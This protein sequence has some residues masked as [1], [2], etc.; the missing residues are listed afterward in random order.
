MNSI[1]QDDTAGKKK[2]AEEGNQS[3]QEIINQLREHQK[4]IQVNPVET[5]RKVS[6]CSKI[7]F[8]YRRLF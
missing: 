3:A 6:L 5:S 4:V 1:V 2:E 7:Y 8:Y